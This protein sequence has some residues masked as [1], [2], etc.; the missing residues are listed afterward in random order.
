MNLVPNNGVDPSMN[1]SSN[2]PFAWKLIAGLAGFKLFL[3][4]VTVGAWGSEWF[5]DELYS[6]PYNHAE[7]YLCR[8][9]KMPME[10]LWPRTKNYS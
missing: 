2:P 9:L 6:M 8:G 3:H 1:S 10:E 4:L 5:V 7:I